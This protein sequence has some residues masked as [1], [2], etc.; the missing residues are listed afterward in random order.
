M[1]SFVAY[2]YKIVEVISKFSAL[3]FCPVAGTMPVG[4]RKWHNMIDIDI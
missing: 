4:M 2:H 1:I 3:P